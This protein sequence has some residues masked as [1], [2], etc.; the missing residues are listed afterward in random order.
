MAELNWNRH[1][2]GMATASP[3][4]TSN[5]GADSA[6]SPPGQRPDLA[7]PFQDIPDFLNGPVTY[8]AGDLARRQRDLNH[9]GAGCAVTVVDEQANLRAIGSDGVGLIPPAAPAAELAGGLPRGSSSGIPWRDD[10]GE[11]PS[12]RD[13][14]LT[15]SRNC[16]SSEFPV[17]S[18]NTCLMLVTPS[19]RFLAILAARGM[20][21]KYKL[22]Q[23]SGGHAG[24][25]SEMV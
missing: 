24:N 9:A 1:P 11:P 25:H 13:R 22:S 5:G 16:S 3:G 21:G 18:V 17:C 15:S 10:S 19:A 2:V 14:P 6:G 20:F 7:P 8:G 23:R 4:D 12:S